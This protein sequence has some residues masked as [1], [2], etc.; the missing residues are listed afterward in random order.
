MGGLD[1][2]SVLKC[3]AKRTLWLS[4]DKE[5]KAL[6]TSESVAPCEGHNYSGY[7]RFY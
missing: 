4:G 1:W 2:R 3:G 7:F 5:Y 6:L